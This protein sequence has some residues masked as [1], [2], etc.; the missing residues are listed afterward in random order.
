MTKQVDLSVIIPAYREAENLRLLLPRLIKVLDGMSL[1]CE[2]LIVDTDP[3]KDETPD[4]CREWPVRLVPRVGGES[5]GDAV[6]TGIASCVGEYVL[7]MDAD[8]SHAPEFIP[9]L[10]G[11]AKENDV[12]V[13][14]RYVAGGD[15]ENPWSLILMSRIL[16]VIYSVAL[17]LDCRDVSN[18]FK[19]YCGELIR[20]LSLRCRHFDIVEELMVMAR[21]RAGRLRIKEVPFLFKKRMFGETKRNVPLFV[22]SFY[23]TLIKLLFMRIKGRRS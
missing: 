13:A 10:W 9:S 17:G 14:S 1:C 6:R 3:S 12:V 7:F 8:G 5:Y 22:V 15:T 21:I 4:V 20:P 11:H 2:I 23:V 19:L 16:N 18:S